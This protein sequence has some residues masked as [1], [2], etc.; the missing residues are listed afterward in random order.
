MDTYQPMYPSR[1]KVSD[2]QTVAEQLDDPGLKISMHPENPSPA[3]VLL[4]APLNTLCTEHTMKLRR[5]CLQT[6]AS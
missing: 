5:V 3:R 2:F 6:A 4:C 1:Q